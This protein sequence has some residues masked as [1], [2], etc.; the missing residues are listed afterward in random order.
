M[1]DY[2]AQVC[3]D[4]FFS[5][6]ATFVTGQLQFS[7]ENSEI[8]PID[9]S[10]SIPENFLTKPEEAIPHQKKTTSIPM[11][12]RD[13]YQG[14]SDNIVSPTRRDSGSY[15]SNMEGASGNNR[16]NNGNGN[17]TSP[18]KRFKCDTCDRVFAQKNL[19]IKHM[20]KHTGEKPYDCHLCPKSFAQLDYLISHTR[21]H[22]GEKPF[23]C[24]QCEK[25]FASNQNLTAHMKFHSGDYPLVC[26]T[27]G[28]AFPLEQSVKFAKHVKNH[29]IPKPNKCAQCPKAFKDKYMLALHMRVHTGEKPYQCMLCDK[30]YQTKQNLHNHQKTHTEML[31]HVQE[32][33]QG[34]MED[35]EGGSFDGKKMAF[36]MFS[37]HNTGN[38]GPHQQNNSEKMDL[39][40]KY[41]NPNELE[42]SRKYPNPNEMELSRKYSNPN[43]MD[44]NRHPVSHQ[45]N[46]SERM[47]L[48]QSLYLKKMSQEH[49]QMN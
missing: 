24:T 42:L 6:N 43:E 9:F 33:V 37:R 32:V 46:N 30:A 36:D 4:Y 22:T 41:P 25:A 5:Y 23:Q 26:L 16:I 34:F 38:A 1:V 11:H 27:C 14:T 2:V 39:P 8:I 28:K 21:T 20:R 47:E 3:Q 31:G 12:D 18:E 44:I 7:F 35:P 19:L 49:G 17:N 45:L 15:E 10:D 29:T 48:S 13:I 40:R